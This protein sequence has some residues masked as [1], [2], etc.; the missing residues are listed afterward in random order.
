GNDPKDRGID[1]RSFGLENGLWLNAGEEVARTLEDARGKF[2]RRCASLEAGRRL[3]SRAP[4]ANSEEYLRP[5]VEF[6][7]R[8]AVE[9]MEFILKALA[10]HRVVVLGEVHHRPR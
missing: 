9:P 2:A 3:T 1:I 7:K 10:S 4:I 5:F 8:E 6:L